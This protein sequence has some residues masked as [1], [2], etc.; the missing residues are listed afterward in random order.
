MSNGPKTYTQLR[1]LTS[2]NVSAKPT[3]TMPDELCLL[4][5]EEIQENRSIESTRKWKS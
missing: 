4:N 1:G 2:E 5:L 3:N